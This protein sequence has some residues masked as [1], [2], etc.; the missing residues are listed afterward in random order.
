MDSV[1]RYFRRPPYDGTAIEFFI[2]TREEAD[3]KGIKYRKNWR[4]GEAGDWVLTDDDYVL[5]VV[6]THPWKG[7]ERRSVQFA[8]GRKIVVMTKQGQK[9]TNKKTPFLFAAYRDYPGGADLSAHRV[10]HPY[11][12]L[13]RKT[14]IKMAIE[15]YVQL[16][17]FKGGRLTEED[18]RKIGRIYRPKDLIPELAFGWL[19]KVPQIHRAAMKRLAE[20]LTQQNVTYETVIETIKK[21]K[22]IAE[23]EGHSTSLLKAAE[24]EL[25]LLRSAFP[26]TP[27]RYDGL[28]GGYD[29][30]VI[31]NEIPEETESQKRITKELEEAHG[32][33]IKKRKK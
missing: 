29:A 1:V 9:K 26:D 16:W 6:Y 5:Q 10:Q 21:A 30:D 31:L 2:Y 33:Q 28:E 3:K 23:S 27:K 20:V 25:N 14:K 15:L 8:V 17:I 18:K 32:E 12:S 24:F 13:V 11:D 22:Q 19:F 7:Y 4:K